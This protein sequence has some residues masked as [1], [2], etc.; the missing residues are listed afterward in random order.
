QVGLDGAVSAVATRI[1]CLFPH[2][3][4]LRFVG[5]V[6]EQLLPRQPELRFRLAPSSVVVHQHRRGAGLDLVTTAR[7]Q[8]SGLEETRRDEPDEPFHRYNLGI[9]LDR[10]G[11]HAEAELE[12]TTALDLAPPH[13]VWSAPAHAALAHSVRAQGRRDEAVALNKQATKQDPDWAHGW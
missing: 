12:L 10:L 4:D 13:T 11:L 1:V 9:A 5:R 7:R 6:G 2:R 3:P 8:L